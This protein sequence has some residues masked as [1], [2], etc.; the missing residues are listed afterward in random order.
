MATIGSACR[1]RRSAVM[2]NSAWRVS[3]TTIT[4][5]RSTDWGGRSHRTPPAPRSIAWAMKPW[6]SCCSP[7]SA[8]NRPPGFTSRESVNIAF[9]DASC[10]PLSRRPP[11]ASTTSLTDIDT[12]SLLSL[13]V[14]RRDLPL[15]DK[16]ACDAVQDRG[17]DVGA[18][19]EPLR[20]TRDHHRDEL[21]VIGGHEAD[22]GTDRLVLGVASVFRDAGGAGLHGQ[23]VVEAIAP[24][25]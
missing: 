17:G 5:V 25:G 14:S 13:A 16:R 23:S 10:E 6:P 18:S 11:V 8:T 15:G 24:S 22:E 21:R 9:N 2:S 1:R 4:A 20:L 7:R 19:E 12:A 3:G